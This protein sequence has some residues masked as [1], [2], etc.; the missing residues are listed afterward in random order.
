MVETIKQPPPAAAL[1]VPCDSDALKGQ[2]GE[3]GEF[4][5]KNLD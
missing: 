4:F 1:D 2:F 3:A 5:A